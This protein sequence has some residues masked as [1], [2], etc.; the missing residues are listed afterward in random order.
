MDLSFHYS[1]TPFFVRAVA[2]DVA[3]IATWIEPVPQG[4]FE[5]LDVRKTTIGLAPP[6]RLAVIGDFEDVA[7]YRRERTS[8][9]SVPNVESSSCASQAA[10]RSQRH[11]VQ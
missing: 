6:N 10:H 9:R 4:T 5:R 7:D 8:P 3:E 2:V 1:L 11:C